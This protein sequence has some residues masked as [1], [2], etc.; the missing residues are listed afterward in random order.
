MFQRAI[1]PAFGLILPLMGL[2]AMAQSLPE[3]LSDTV[4]DFADVLD[5]TEEGR[6]ARLL[7]QMRDETGVHMVVATMGDIADHGGAGMRLDAYGKALFN[8]WGVGD[9]ERNDGLLLLVVTEAREARIALGTGYDAVYDGRAARVLSTAVLPEFREGRLAAG[10]EAGVVASR[11]R[12]VVPFLEG[13]P[14]TV[15]E[16]FREPVAERDL[17]WLLGLGGVGGIAAFGF[18]R[19]RAKRRCPS[20]GKDMLDHTHEVIEAP[21]SLTSGTGMHHM[22]CRS[23]GFNDRT[24]YSIRHGLGLR[25]PGGFRRGSGGSGRSGGFGGGRSS[26]GGASGKW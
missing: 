12:L 8:A 11:D 13:R 17:S 22:T 25:S 5:A 16:G 21:T 4:S 6:I 19:M 23:C 15:T 1:A 18:W 20:C 9:A 24:T 7:Q 2:A 14:V 3:P 10:I 26:G